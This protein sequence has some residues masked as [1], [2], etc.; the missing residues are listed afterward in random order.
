[1]VQAAQAQIISIV[2]DF[3]EIPKGSVYLSRSLLG[4]YRPYI[5]FNLHWL[6]YINFGSTLLIALSKA[7]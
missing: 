5:W 7:L 4:F 2:A 6:S 3:K 1:V